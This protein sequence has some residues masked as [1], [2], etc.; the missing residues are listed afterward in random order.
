MAKKL[1]SQTMQAWI[2]QIQGLAFHMEHAKIAVTDQDK[3]LAITMGLP[4]S[5]DNVI[6]NFNSMSPETLTFD[7][8]ITRLLNEEVWQ[9]TATPLVKEDNQIKMELDEAM[10]VSCAKAISEVLCFFCD[11]KGHYKSDCPGRKAWEKSKSKK[12]TGTAAGV[13]DSSDDEAF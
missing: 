4:P 2:G 13:W 12:T 9:I 7:P 11:A 6:I 10:A 5:F 3:I 8:I 1:D